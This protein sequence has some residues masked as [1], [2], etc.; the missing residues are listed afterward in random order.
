[1]LFSHFWELVPQH[2]RTKRTLT[3][4]YW[5]AQRLDDIAES[6]ILPAYRRWL[7]SGDWQE[8]PRYVPHPLKWLRDEGWDSAPLKPQY[9]D[10]PGWTLEQLESMLSTAT[11]A[12]WPDMM[13]MVR[14]FH[15]DHEQTLA[16]RFP[17]PAGVEG[18]PDAD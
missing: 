7:E 9:A 17:Q 12:N 4:Q 16:A 13:A 2:R 10:A 8:D 3:L 1:L 14:E 11:R 18:G 15:P 5:V 6:S